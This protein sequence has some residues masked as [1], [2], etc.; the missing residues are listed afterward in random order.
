MSGIHGC[1]SVF[2]SKS[3]LR[4][5]ASGGRHRNRTLGKHNAAA[6][7]RLCPFGLILFERAKGYSAPLY[8]LVKRPSLANADRVADASEAGN[9]SA[10]MWWSS[11]P[12]VESVDC[13][14]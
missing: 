2:G 6:D 13:L 11:F 3:P 8:L 12:P 1:L 14:S 9:T 7:R 4:P 10:R 5:L